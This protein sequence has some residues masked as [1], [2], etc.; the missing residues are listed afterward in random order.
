MHVTFKETQN[1]KFFEILDDINKTV[2]HLSFNDKTLMKANI[3]K[4]DKD[5]PSSSN[6]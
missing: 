4:M 3:E 2:Q 6:Q 5:Q 1:V